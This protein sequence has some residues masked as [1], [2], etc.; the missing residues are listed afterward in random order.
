MSEQDNQELMLQAL[1]QTR[2]YG[3]ELIGA[4]SRITE[5]LRRG[6]QENGLNLLRQLLEGVGCMT[7]ALCLTSPLLLQRQV[8]IDISQLPETLTPLVEAL[9][10]KDYGLIGDILSYELQPILEK[11]TDQLG[12]MNGSSEGP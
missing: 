11:W 4:C 10:N 12:S 1:D 5:H 6:E 2:A 3:N 8:Q 7:K 9:E